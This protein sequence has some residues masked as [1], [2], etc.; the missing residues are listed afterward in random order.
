MHLQFWLEPSR[1]R[2]T[3]IESDP[4]LLRFRQAVKS[5]LAVAVNVAIFWRASDVVS[6]FA[7]ISAAFLMQ[8]V[9]TGTPRRQRFTMAG[10]ACAIMIVAP[11]GSALHGRRGAEVVLLVLWAACVF[12]ARRF[13]KGN[14]GFTLFAFTEVLLATALPG[15]P[16]AQFLTAASGLVVA[17]VFRFWIWPADEVRAFDDAAA[18]FFTR[19]RAMTNGPD[20]DGARQLAHLRASA[21]FANQILSDHPELDRD[22]SRRAIVTQEYELLQ[23]LRMLSEAKTRAREGKATIACGGVHAAIRDLALCRLQPLLRTPPSFR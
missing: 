22:G 23:S 17:Y 4:G 7:A 19:A 18:I 5:V 10:T 16:E 6:L 13:L 21:S 20:R 8:C 9:D 14:G 3:L 12:Y 1:A 2:N 11:I 15:N